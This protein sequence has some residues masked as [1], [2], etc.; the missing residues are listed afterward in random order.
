MST[1]PKVTLYALSS[2]HHCR[3]VK[4]LLAQSNVHHQVIEV[5]RLTAEQRRDV[6][7]QVRQYNNQVSFPTTVIGKTVVVGNKDYKIREA[8]EMLSET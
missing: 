1:K 5:D 8:L 7:E 6:L 2:C 3:S 4:N